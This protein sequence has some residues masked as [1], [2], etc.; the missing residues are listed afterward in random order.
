[1]VGCGR[2]VVVGVVGGNRRTSSEANARVASEFPNIVGLRFSCCFR[3]FRVLGSTSNERRT[4][5]G[6]PVAVSGCYVRKVCFSFLFLIKWV[7][8]LRRRVQWGG[9]RLTSAT[10][11]DFG[12]FWLS[13]FS[14]LAGAFAV[15]F[16]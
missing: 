16:R 15:W 1:M 7:I 14:N 10:G 4:E 11:G 9:E 12:R 5:G 13:I 6:L 8:A 2:A 3:G